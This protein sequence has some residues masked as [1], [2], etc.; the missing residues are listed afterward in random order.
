MECFWDLAYR[1]G[2]HA[3]HWEAD[4]VPQELAMMVAAGWVPAGGVVLDVGCGGGIEAIFMASQGFRTIGVDR[5]AAALEIARERASAAGVEVDW[6]QGDALALPVEPGS[7]DLALDRGCFHVIARKRRRA[8][9]REIARVLR[10][11]GKLLLRGARRD[12]EEEG[13]VRI[14]AREVDRWFG[15]EGL[16][17]GP[18]VPIALVAR[19]GV[20]DGN[21]VV[22]RK[23]SRARAE[24][25]CAQR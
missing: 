3:E 20:L 8:Y 19:S 23:S 18:V 1:S 15:A 16:E 11:G 21:L 5:S 4:W 22:V 10:P 24:L 13:Y 7:V 9:A 12:N 6:R 14:D 25:E 2:H 17:R